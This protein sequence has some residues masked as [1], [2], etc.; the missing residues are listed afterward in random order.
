[1][2]VRKAKAAETQAALKDAARRLFTAL[3]ALLS[4]PLTFYQGFVRQHAYG[5]SNQSLESWA[6]DWAESWRRRC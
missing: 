4:L 3:S 2:G 5:L 6:K 1:M